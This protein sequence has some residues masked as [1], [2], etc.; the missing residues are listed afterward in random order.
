MS[1]M[2]SF[3][4][5]FRNAGFYGY[6]ILLCALLALMVCVAALMG[7]LASG[8]SRTWLW[9]A[10]GGL[11]FT[12]IGLSLGGIGNW[13]SRR[14]VDR[15]LSEESISWTV[16]E[17]VYVEGYSEARDVSVVALI[18]LTL[19]LLIGL[20][21]AG[22]SATQ[23]RTKT[24]AR[25]RFDLAAVGLTV[26]FALLGAV[27]SLVGL[28]SSEAAAKERART[29]VNGK[30]KA[31]LARTN[32]DVCEHLG[33]AL[34]WRGAEALEAEVPGVR[35]RAR[36]CVDDKLAEIDKPLEGSPVKE[37]KAALEG[38]RESPLLIDPA[39]KK[40]VAELIVEEE[41][42]AVKAA[43]PVMPEPIKPSGN[44]KVKIRLGA[45]S[46]NG[47]LPPEAVQRIVWQNYGRF[48]ACYEDGLKRNPGIEGKVS[49]H[50][51]IGQDGTISSVANEGSDLPDAE[52]IACVERAFE[53]LTFPAPESGIVTVNHRMIFSPGT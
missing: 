32:Y 17:R 1:P 26:A 19:P 14:M 18:F 37:C 46:V 13:S 38:L 4:T 34:Q 9:L 35:D 40:K 31:M 45:I 20:G 21:A 27:S 52:V 39:Q 3:W 29:V 23:A 36:K 8:K 22:I 25:P 16:M 53:G 11:S 24:G 48:S 30:L 43:R 6:G 2:V 50:F 5:I 49:V 41:A 33:E 42:K 10:A 44:R 7:S 28:P 51:V 12:G 15:V 47:R